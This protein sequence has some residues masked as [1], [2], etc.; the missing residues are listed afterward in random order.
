[1]ISPI[2]FICVEVRRGGFL[3]LRLA[4]KAFF[5]KAAAPLTTASFFQIQGAKTV[6]VFHAGLKQAVQSDTVAAVFAS[7]NEAVDLW[8]RV[9]R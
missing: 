5:Q 2:A 3:K 6:Q 8:F 9:E 4:V 1:M 7:D